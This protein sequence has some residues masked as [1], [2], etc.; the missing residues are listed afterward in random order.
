MLKPNTKRKP[1]KK[2]LLVGINK[3]R[4]DLNAD[5]RGCVNDVENM[6]HML[7]KLFGFK[8]ENIR[9]I[10]DERATR[11]NII[12]RLRWLLKG[13]RKG[14]EL[15]FH[16]SGH[17]SQIR[18]R[19]GDELDDQLDEILCPHDLDWER[20]LSDDILAKI[21]KKLPKGVNLTMLC[22]SCHSGTMTRGLDNPIYRA[23]R[24]ITPPFDIRCR[25]LGREVPTRRM[26]KKPKG[27]QRHVLLSGCMDY[28]TSADAY[29]NNV[30]QGAF[31]WA[32]TSAVKDNPNITWREAHKE[33][34][35]KLGGYPQQPQLSGDKSLLDRKVFGGKV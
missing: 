29:I 11:H 1:V 8:P 28:Q 4:P 2:A 12:K 17:G 20:P 6:R 32:F 22:D 33:V 31:T 21:F 26:G 34:L 35:T 16:Y 25:S 15:V 13:A 19:N 5:L 14:D 27:S 30:Y 7:I 18:D 9:V 23:P 24:F 10:I 3:Y